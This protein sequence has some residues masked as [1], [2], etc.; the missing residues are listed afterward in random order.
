MVAVL[1][2]DLAMAFHLVV[3]VDLKQETQELVEDLV[4]KEVLVVQEITFLVNGKP[5]AEA[6]AL[7]VLELMD[8][9]VDQMVILEERVDSVVQAL[10]LHYLLLVVLHMLVVA[11]VVETQVL[12][13]LLVVVVLADL[14]QETTENLVKEAAV[15]AQ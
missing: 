13:M 5:A 6:A 3:A 12:I 7:V 9:T 10:K 8:V 4:L 1:V 2:L 11:V 14:V 15:A